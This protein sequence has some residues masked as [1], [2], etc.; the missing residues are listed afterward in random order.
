MRDD[1][2]H[3]FWDIDLFNVELPIASESQHQVY[4]GE[5]GIASIT[6]SHELQCVVPD[7]CNTYDTS[8]N[9]IGK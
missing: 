4:T 8:A 5:N 9:L 3:R 7:N 2:A 6:L 1:N